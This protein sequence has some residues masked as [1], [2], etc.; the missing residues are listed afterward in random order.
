VVHFH[1]EKVD[2]EFSRPREILNV[3]HDVVDSAYFEWGIHSDAPFGQ[4]SKLLL[5]KKNLLILLGLVLESLGVEV[6]YFNR[7]DFIGVPD[8]WIYTFAIDEL[9]HLGKDSH[10]LI[11]HKT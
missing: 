9:A 1:A 6:V 2:V 8:R 5:L 3:K 10:A 4:N 11:A 7:F